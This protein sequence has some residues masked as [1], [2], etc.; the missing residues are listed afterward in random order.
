MMRLRIMD[1]AVLLRVFFECSGLL[2]TTYAIHHIH[3]THQKLNHAH[4][5]CKQTTY[6]PEVGCYVVPNSIA[7]DKAVFIATDLEKYT[8]YEDKVKKL[9]RAKRKL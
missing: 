5:N 3:Y 1:T 6:E 9:C 2:G 8:S 7:I 4:W